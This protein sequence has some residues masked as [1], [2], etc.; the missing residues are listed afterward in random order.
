MKVS[1]QPLTMQ[2]FAEFFKLLPERAESGHSWRV[3]VEEIQAKNFDL[4]AVNPHRKAP[5]DTRTP[6][7]LLS[8]VESQMTQISEA[9]TRLRS[10]GI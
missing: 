6:E 7:E 4:R 8:I 3:S 2:H 9:I 5:E 1:R 10:K